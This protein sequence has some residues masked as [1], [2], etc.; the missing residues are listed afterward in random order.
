MRTSPGYSLQP[1]KR[2]C[3]CV[4]EHCL[5]TPDM[6]IPGLMNKVV[7]F[8][9]GVPNLHMSKRTSCKLQWWTSLWNESSFHNIDDLGFSMLTMT[10][11]SWAYAASSKV[12]NV[13][14]FAFCRC[15]LD[16]GDRSGNPSGWCRDLAQVMQE[17]RKVQSIM[18]AS[19][20]KQV[21]VDSQ[22]LWASLCMMLLE[23]Q[24]WHAGHAV[25]GAW[26]CKMYVAQ[27]VHIHG[28]LDFQDEALQGDVV[29]W[30]KLHILRTNMYKLLHEECSNHLKE[31]MWW[32]VWDWEKDLWQVSILGKCG[33][34][35][36]VVDGLG[37]VTI[38]GKDLHHYDFV[39]WIRLRWVCYLQLRLTSACLVE[40]QI[41]KKQTWQEE[42]SSRHMK[43]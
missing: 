38:T 35:W 26:R 15:C 23:P 30:V 17:I 11:L 31:V 42:L 6:S 32:H 25:A 24:P 21:R 10:P 33:H 13:M 40:R 43:G 5:A 3:G 18:W 7:G 22:K 29:T 2:T 4:H 36:Y 12:L 9:K 8:L 1:L 34:A 14:E 19:G 16:R 39:D 28:A 37:E 41:W 20:N 27:Q